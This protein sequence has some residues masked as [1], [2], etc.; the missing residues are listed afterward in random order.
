MSPLEKENRILRHTLHILNGKA[1]RNRDMLHTFQEIELCLLSC[2]GFDDLLDMILISLK[3]YFSLDAVNLV[4]FDPEQ[5]TQDLLKNYQL[6][7]FP[8]C[9]K[10]TES[11]HSLKQLYPGTHKPHLGVPGQKLKEYAFT[12][13]PRI[14]SSALL[15]L[16]RHN[17]IIGSLHLGSNDPSRYHKDV[18]TDYITHFA[19][20]ISVCIE[21]C[22]NQETLHRLSIIDM[23]TKVN[24]R[25]SFDQELLKEISRSNR[26]QA[27][28][29]C[30]FVDLDHFKQINDSYGH[31]TGDRVLHRTA[32]TIKRQLRKIDFIARYGGEEF[33]VLLPACDNTRAQQI[34]E[35]IRAKVERTQFVSEVGEPIKLTLSIGIS[36]CP[37]HEHDA[38]NIK[39]MAKM[40]VA[41]A[42]KGVYE[43]KRRGRNCV[44]YLPEEMKIPFSEK[45]L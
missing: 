16:V 13:R 30:L 20:I 34:A 8:G 44:V 9:L 7:P 27:P 14:Q 38:A 23:L 29:S 28:M 31:Q 1:E 17:I 45:Y 43:A 4:I 32:Q 42:D 10:F 12:A 26:N 11:Y 36:T 3:E 18:A 24:N 41:C 19:S 15:P 40:V 35:N 37:P 5:T 39:E 2:N 33:A 6:P 21:N 22:I 25:R